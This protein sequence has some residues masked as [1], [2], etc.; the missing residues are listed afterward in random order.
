MTWENGVRELPLILGGVWGRHTEKGHRD[1]TDPCGRQWKGDKT[2]G[3]TA[4]EAGLSLERN[5]Q[6]A[7]LG[8]TT[9]GRDPQGAEQALLEGGLRQGL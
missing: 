3:E 7:E 4:E 9:G 5:P 1:R 6:E 2:Q 8:C